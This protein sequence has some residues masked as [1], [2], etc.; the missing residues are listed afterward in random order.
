[1][2]PIRLPLRPGVN[3]QRPYYG[4]AELL[5][6]PFRF[7]GDL[8]HAAKHEQR[9]STHRDAVALRNQAVR[10]LVHD[11]RREEQQAAH[12][13]QRP[14]E[15]CRLVV[16]GFRVQ[17]AAQDVHEEREREQPRRIDLDRYA[18]QREDA[19]V[20]DEQELRFPAAGLP[21]PHHPTSTLA[22]VLVCAP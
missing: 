3:A 2:M 21:R 20:T 1:M 10:Q 16:Q 19:V 17:F 22:Y 4:G 11:D 15:P 12:Q 14:Q 8:R 9:D 13:R 5:E 7:P 6:W 18:E